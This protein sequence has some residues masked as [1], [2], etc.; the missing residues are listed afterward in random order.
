LADK[1]VALVIGNS[2]Y[3]Q[4]S[5]LPNPVNDASDMSAAL[6][7]VGFEVTLGLDV[8]KRAFDAKVREFARTLE[9]ADVA[10]FFYAGHGLQVGGRNYLVPV[11][12]RLQGERDLDF[13]TVGVDFI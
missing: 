13:D 6:R 10:L 7:N 8:D 3:L 9:G 12:A 2:A 11:D 4:S 1:R 5:A